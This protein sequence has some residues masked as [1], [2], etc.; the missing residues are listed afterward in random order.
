VPSITVPRSSD[1]TAGVLTANGP[2]TNA[3]LASGAVNKLY[4]EEREFVVTGTWPAAV[5][6]VALISPLIRHQ[7][8]KRRLAEQVVIVSDDD[9]SWFCRF[10]LPVQARNV[11]DIDGSKRTKNLWYEESLPPDTVLYALGMGRDE[12][13]RDVLSTS[14]PENDP[15][16]QIGGNET[17]GNGWVVVSVVQ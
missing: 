1:G 4:L 9:F 11:L 2:S 17:V 6:V 14:F 10:S 5:D 12:S 8:T 16:L 13:A 3:N 15:Y 7:E